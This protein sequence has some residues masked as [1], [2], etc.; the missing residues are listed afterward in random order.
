MEW[1][2]EF[3]ET[4]R[5][6]ESSDF[7]STGKIKTADGRS[8]DFSLDLSMCRD[9]ECERKT[10]DSGKVVFRDPLVIRPRQGRR[11]LGQAFFL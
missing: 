5:E 2:C 7:T 11:S 8:L 10:M 6:H 9:F 1:K 4:I 3:T